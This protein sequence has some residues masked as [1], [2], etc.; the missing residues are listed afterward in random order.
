MSAASIVG[1]SRCIR[2]VLALIPALKILVFDPM[3]GFM[4]RHIEEDE[5]II[6][7]A[8]SVGILT[9]EIKTGGQS[10]SFASLVGY[11]FLGT[12]NR[13]AIDASQSQ[14]GLSLLDDDIQS[15]ILTKC[16]TSY[17][18][19]F[20]DFHHEPTIP[21]GRSPSKTRKSVH[22]GQIDQT[23]LIDDKERNGSNTFS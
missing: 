11:G 21:M 19:S 2:W 6:H 7:Y 3:V 4:F 15:P 20:A 18:D 9:P 22:F 14:V 10:G 8:E 17:G 5:G 16:T 1:L 23:Q 13:D 12:S